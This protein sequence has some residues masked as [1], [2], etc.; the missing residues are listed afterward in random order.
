MYPL[1]VETSVVAGY[2]KDKSGEKKL[3]WLL[4]RGVRYSG[5][6]YISQDQFD[7]N[8]KNKRKILP[9][10]EINQYLKK[11]DMVVVYPIQAPKGFSADVTLRK[12]SKNDLKLPVHI[13]KT[14]VD[15]DYPYLTSELAT[16]LNKNESF[17]SKMIQKLSLKNDKQYHESIRSGKNSKV[18]RYSEKAFQFLRDFLQKTPSFNPYKA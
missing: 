3:L 4:E 9:H 7:E 13:K 2:K 1:T 8:F 14:D 11:T 12:G 18:Q 5:A 6:P 16:K 15:Q 17:T 10:L